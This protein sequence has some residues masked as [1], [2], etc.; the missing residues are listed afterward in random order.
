MV[1]Q[2]PRGNNIVAY[3]IVT[4]IMFSSYF[5]PKVEPKQ[6]ISRYRC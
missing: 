6:L 3:V 1:I 4:N 5:K 2:E